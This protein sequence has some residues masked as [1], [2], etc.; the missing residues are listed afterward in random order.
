MMFR[1]GKGRF[2]L[3]IYIEFIVSSLNVKYLKNDSKY[4]IDF[5]LKEMNV[6]MVLE[7]KACS[8]V[9]QILR[10]YPIFSVACHF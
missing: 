9:I 5:F 3:V 8:Q 6:K 2:K 1:N 7:N 10:K 4:K